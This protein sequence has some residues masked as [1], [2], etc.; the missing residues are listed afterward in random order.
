MDESD[1]SDAAV[2]ETFG[3]SSPSTPAIAAHIEKSPIT[4]AKT[5]SVSITGSVPALIFGS[6]RIPNVDKAKD[7]YVNKPYFMGL[8][9][10]GDAIRAVVIA[11]IRYSPE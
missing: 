4:A 9:R 2:A 10:N 5:H 11:R 3:A 1:G 8:N 7:A 6:F